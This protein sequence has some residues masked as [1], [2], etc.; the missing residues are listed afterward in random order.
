[1]T[2]VHGPDAEP[3]RVEALL[4][5]GA[6]TIVAPGATGAERTTA[7]LGE[8]GRRGLTSLLLEGGAT[9]GAAFA[10]ADQ[11]DE[12]RVFV[13]PLI[14]GGPLADVPVAG[15]QG[16]L[17]ESKTVGEDTLIRTRFKEW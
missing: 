4:R 7:A 8:L 15:L 5:A 6:E 3:A 13:A 10:A 2:V 12:A 1:V 11:V 16:S 9:L 14:L 17:V